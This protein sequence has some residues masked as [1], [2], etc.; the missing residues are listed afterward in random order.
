MAG[1]V[2][3]QLAARRR[4]LDAGDATGGQGLGRLAAATPSPARAKLLAELRRL[5]ASNDPIS[6]VPRQ[7]RI[8]K[9]QELLANTP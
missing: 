5:Q 7:R 3:D 1:S 4:A 9:I 6:A 2:I 8:A